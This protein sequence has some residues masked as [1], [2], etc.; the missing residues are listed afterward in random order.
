MEA[1][2]DTGC[3]V[4]I[5]VSTSIIVPVNGCFVHMTAVRNEAWQ[6]IKPGGLLM[7]VWECVCVRV[8]ERACP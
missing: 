7:C 5:T 2:V 3:G 1:V 8:R 4:S 6:A